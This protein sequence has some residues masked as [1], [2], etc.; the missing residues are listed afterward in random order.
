ME[1]VNLNLAKCLVSKTGFTGD[2]IH[3]VCSGAVKFVPHGAMDYVAG[4][5][6]LVFSAAATAG[7][8]GCIIGLIITIRS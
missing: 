4:S 1:E 6:L 2:T 5:F 8:I 3:N 7:I